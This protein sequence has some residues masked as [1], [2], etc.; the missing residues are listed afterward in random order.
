MIYHVVSVGTKL[1]L[2]HVVEAHTP[3]LLPSHQVSPQAFLTCHIYR[4]SNKS[5]TPS[6]LV[7]K[8]SSP[9]QVSPS[10]EGVP[11]SLYTIINAT[12]H[13][14]RGPKT[15]RRA[16]KEAPGHLLYTW[17][18]ERLDHKVG[19]P[20]TLPFSRSNI[21]LITLLACAKT[22]DYSTKHFD[23]LDVFPRPPQLFNS[24]IHQPQMGEWRGYK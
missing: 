2:V 13:Q 7:T 24:R 19:T 6:L 1:T 14:A 11:C 20:C 4:F 22:F 18:T 15:C 5:L 16:T 9:L 8:M 3:V 12:P 21:T 17:L 10:R 23:E